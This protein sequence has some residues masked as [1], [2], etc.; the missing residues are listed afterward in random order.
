MI[1]HQPSPEASESE[2]HGEQHI[3]HDPLHFGAIALSK[4][5]RRQRLHSFTPTRWILLPDR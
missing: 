1:N 3:S 4:V 5:A 2:R